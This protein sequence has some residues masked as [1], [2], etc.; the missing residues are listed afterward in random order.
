MRAAVREDLHN[1]ITSFVISGVF[2]PVNSS[3]ETLVGHLVEDEVQQ[4]STKSGGRPSCSNP[5]QFFP[6]C[7][8]T[9]CS[10][11]VTIVDL[12]GSNIRL[13]NN[14]G[15]THAGKPINAHI[16]L[17]HE[18]AQI[19]LLER[20]NAAILNAVLRPLA[21]RLIPAFQGAMQRAGIGGQLFLTSNDGTLISAESAV[22]VR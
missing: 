9:P 1:G 8:I 12:H 19:G 16:T 17:S 4:A 22:K 7:S 2:S 14:V 13:N 6:Q 15:D 21:A 10:H 11:I 3:Q 18:V 20:E 5:Q